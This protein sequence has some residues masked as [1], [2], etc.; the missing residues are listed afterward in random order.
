ML[1]AQ[2]LVRVPM[3]VV[4]LLGQGGLIVGG[5]ARQ[6]AREHQMQ[7]Q[8]GRDHQI[9]LVGDGRRGAAGVR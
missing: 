9:G 1:G 4:V 8:G 5:R 2:A 3:L 6:T 7:Q